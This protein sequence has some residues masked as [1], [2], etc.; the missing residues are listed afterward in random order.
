[1]IGKRHDN[2]VRDINGYITVLE[3]SSK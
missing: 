2:L 1:M 3:A